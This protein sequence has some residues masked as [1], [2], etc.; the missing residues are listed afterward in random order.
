MEFLDVLTGIEFF[1]KL[2]E[3][4]AGFGVGITRTTHMD[5]RVRV[6]RKDAFSETFQPLIET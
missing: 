3:M 1:R 6:I 4:R 5:L 2:T